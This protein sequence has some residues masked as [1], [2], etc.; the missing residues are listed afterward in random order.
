M[1]LRTIGAE[2]RF[3]RSSAEITFSLMS[4]TEKVLLVISTGRTQDFLFHTNRRRQNVGASAMVL[5]TADW[6]RGATKGV[7]GVAIL[8]NVSGSAQLLVPSVDVAQSVL[9]EVTC[10]ALVDAPGL[11]IYGWFERTHPDQT[12]LKDRIRHALLQADSL[13]LQLPPNELRNATTPFSAVCEFSTAPAV[14]EPCKVPVTENGR[15]VYETVYCSPTVGKA[16]D[17]A[18]ERLRSLRGQLPFESE[19]DCKS[20]SRAPEGPVLPY[21]KVDDLLTETGWLAV[22]HADGNGFGQAFADVAATHLS[23]LSKNLD[24]IAQESLREAVTRTA[25][26][27]ASD[28]GAKSTWWLLPLIVGGDDFTII[29]DGR[30]AR[31]LTEHY[32]RQFHELASK[33]KI[34]DLLPKGRA[35][36]TVS[37]GIVIS[38]PGF[39]FYDASRLA[40]DLCKSAKKADRTVSAYDLQVVHDSGG[41][42]LNAVRRTEAAA[43]VQPIGHVPVVVAGNPPADADYV[44][45]QQLEASIS[46][47]PTIGGTTMRHRIR[48]GLVGGTQ[49]FS[50][51]RRTL[52]AR[53]STSPRAE[54]RRL[55]DDAR[56]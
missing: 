48:A 34:T 47:L 43:G 25:A 2:V 14:A 8:V 11:E 18:P 3:S 23:K 24:E 30:W 26:D 28:K 42:D 19:S 35:G 5:S 21:I 44:T 49:K 12:T 55:A 51:T 36:L 38:K 41:N 27:V 15:T 52:L 22:I 32:L 16:L 4:L 50:E 29:M 1:S 54:E 53:L 13:R 37:A 40:E 45:C 46:L 39:P 17:K 6:V 56:R 33:Q 20:S 9:R 7:P 31:R 10:K